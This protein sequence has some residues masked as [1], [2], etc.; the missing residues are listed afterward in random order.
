V[1]AVGQSSRSRGGPPLWRRE[2]ASDTADA[3][4]TLI[5]EALRLDTFWHRRVS[6]LPGKE[7]MGVAGTRGG[8]V[9]IVAF[10]ARAVPHQLW[11]TVAALR[12]RLLRVLSSSGV[13]AVDAED[14]VHEAMIRAVCAPR[15][16]RLACAAISR[17][18]LVTWRATR[19][20]CASGRIG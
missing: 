1:A 13:S 10:D 17:W 19:I 15:W 16:I 4:R 20:A 5:S 12:A 9:A 14:L 2:A 18:S 11:Q 6:S 3:D 7:E 8:A